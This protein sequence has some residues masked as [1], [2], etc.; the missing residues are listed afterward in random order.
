[1]LDRREYEAGVRKLIALVDEMSLKLKLMTDAQ[2][3]YLQ[4]RDDYDALRA[5]AEAAK[6]SLGL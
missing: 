1:M 4:A 3:A 2:L 5:R 6:R